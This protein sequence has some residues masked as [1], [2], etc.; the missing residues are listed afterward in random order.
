ME[1]PDRACDRLTQAT[2]VCS[3]IDTWLYV[4]LGEDKLLFS[5]YFKSSFFKNH[6]RHVTRASKQFNGYENRYMK[7]ASL[8]FAQRSSIANI[9]FITAI[10]KGAIGISSLSSIMDDLKLL[11]KSMI[12]Y[13]A[14]EKQDVLV[15]APVLWFE[16]N[17][18][19][20]SGIMWFV[21]TYW[22]APLSQVFC[23]D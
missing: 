2:S 17:T 1:W 6:P 15:V 14:Q 11:R 19:C 4:L 23:L 5:S 12:M 22:F 8:T 18:L 3:A 10:Q 7:C 20:R 9:H 16:T 21:F 13:S